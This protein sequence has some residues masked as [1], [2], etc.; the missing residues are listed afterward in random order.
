MP[1]MREQV[2]SVLFGQLQAV[3]HTVVKRNEA[4]PEKVSAASSSCATAIRASR[5]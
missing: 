2:L 3:S 5:T 1:S 4:L